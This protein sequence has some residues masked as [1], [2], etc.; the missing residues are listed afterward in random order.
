MLSQKSS[1]FFK[2]IGYSGYMQTVYSSF[3]LNTVCL[4]ACSSNKNHE[5]NTFEIK[6]EQIMLKVKFWTPSTTPPIKAKIW[7]SADQ[8]PGNS[9]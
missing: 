5:L 1:I 6:N 3:S 4:L 7:S 9:Y 2:G 8:E